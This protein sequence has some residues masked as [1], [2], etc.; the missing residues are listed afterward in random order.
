MRW[1]KDTLPICRSDDILDLVKECKISIEKA[2]KNNIRI[3]NGNVIPYTNYKGRIKNKE[4]NYIDTD[5]LNPVRTKVREN[6]EK[7][8][9]RSKEEIS[10]RHELRKARQVAA[11]QDLV[12]DKVPTLRQFVQGR[13]NNVALWILKVEKRYAQ[14]STHYPDRI[15]DFVA[16]I[17]AKS[18][19]LYTSIRHKTGISEVFH[20]I[21]QKYLSGTESL[22]LLYNIR[23]V[24]FKETLDTAKCISN[25]ESFL[26]TSELVVKHQLQLLITSNQL[27]QTSRGLFLYND[28]VDY[29][30][31][32]GRKNTAVR[33]DSMTTKCQT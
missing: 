10:R 14:V 16:T 25:I 27:H 33:N 24:E 13:S 9:I 30:K 20:E 7:A 6:K 32:K 1:E 11:G 4:P 8:E 29:D 19:P 28:L 18:G 5:F 2:N 21:R 15:S 26:S 22:D 3:N 31:I 23:S 12:T 17:K